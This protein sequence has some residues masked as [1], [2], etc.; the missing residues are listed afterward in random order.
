M[1]AQADDEE[2]RFRLLSKIAEH[3]K[4]GS[5]IKQQDAFSIMNKGTK[6]RREITK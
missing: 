3:T 6:R 1:F 4:D 2:N 5:E